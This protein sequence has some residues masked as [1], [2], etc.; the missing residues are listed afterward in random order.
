VLTKKSR[1]PR[2]PIGDPADPHGFAALTAAYC[3]A[4]RVK[5]FSEATIGVRRRIFDLFAA[6]ALERGISR[7]NQITR[8]ILERYQRYLF[9]YRR[10]NGQPLSWRGQL[11]RLVPLKSF[12]SWLTRQNLLLYNPAAELEMPRTE[13]RLPKAILSIAEVETVLAQADTREPMG[14][15]DRA[16]LETF[17]STGIRRMELVNL[18]L[19]DLDR[20]RGTLIIRQGKGNKDR[21]VPIG[22][23]ALA[24]LDKY[25]QEVRPLLVVDSK[26]RAIFLSWLGA[27]F[28]GNAMTSLVAD[29]VSAANV[30]KLGSCHLF[31]HTCA[32]L[33]L[34]GGADIRYIQALLG[35][36]Q[37]TTTEIYT[38]VGIRKLKE[39]HSLTH[40]SARLLPPEPPGTAAP[41][42]MAPEPAGALPGSPLEICGRPKLPLDGPTSPDDLDE[43]DDLVDQLAHDAQGDGDEPDGQT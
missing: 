5:N 24:W 38:Q 43:L 9:H 22:E 10:P 32:T 14:I 2:R 23:R 6:W 27:P 17:Y 40:P 20:D 1:F 31:R 36:A 34:E 13:K 21:V 28:S 16:I 37:L 11:T 35:H 15:R 42:P 26:E 19:Q 41:A 7:P 3:E 12:F 29:Y 33:M 4:M 8:P 25:L 39:V 18:S 30:G